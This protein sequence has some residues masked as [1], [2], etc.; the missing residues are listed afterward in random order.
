MFGRREPTAGTPDSSAAL[1]PSMLSS[2]AMATAPGSQSEGNSWF[3]FLKKRDFESC[4]KP[5]LSVLYRVAK[6]MGCSD[7]ES[8]DLVQITLIKAFQAW[9]RFDGRHVRSWLIRILRN[10]RLM[11]VRTARDLMSLDTPEADEVAEEDFWPRLE[12]KLTAE[13]LM[14]AIAQLPELYRIT[15]HLCDVEQM[16]YEEAAEAMDIPVGT[17]RSR[18]FRARSLVRAA[19]AAHMISPNGEVEE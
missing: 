4:M 7:A 17:V 1:T 3:G 19:M 8:E 16:S 15:I 10:E 5:E 9:D 12:G 13:L 6:R 11:Q 14:E 2:A 18:L